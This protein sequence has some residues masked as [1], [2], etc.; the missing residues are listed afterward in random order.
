MPSVTFQN[1]HQHIPYHLW[2]TATHFDKAHIINNDASCCHPPGLQS[3]IRSLQDPTT[4]KYIQVPL[5]L[6]TTRINFFLTNL[7]HSMIDPFSIT[8]DFEDAV[9]SW[10]WP[11]PPRVLCHRHYWHW[12]WDLP[13][14]WCH[15]SYT[16]LYITFHKYIC[17]CMFALALCFTPSHRPWQSWSDNGLRMTQLAL[18]NFK[19]KVNYMSFPTAR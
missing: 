4:A 11:P 19:T 2:A 7:R 15:L 6:G 12:E 16:P 1:Y 14:I 18:D 3:I 13:G 8:F 17:P 10:Y 9:V 5:A